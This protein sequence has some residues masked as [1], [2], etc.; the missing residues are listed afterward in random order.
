MEP[1]FLEEKFGPVPTRLLN[2]IILMSNIEYFMLRFFHEFLRVDRYV[3]RCE[4][5][6]LT[7]GV[8]RVSEG[9]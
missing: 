8:Y 2:S 5:R 7:T 9:D 6:W 4:I 1:V 3:Y